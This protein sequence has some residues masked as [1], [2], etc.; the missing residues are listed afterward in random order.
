MSRFVQKPPTPRMDSGPFRKVWRSVSA[1]GLQRLKKLAV[2]SPGFRY[3]GESDDLSKHLFR[4]P[5]LEIYSR[6]MDNV[7][8]DH[9]KDCPGDMLSQQND[10]RDYKPKKIYPLPRIASDMFSS[11]TTNSQSRLTFNVDDEKE[12]ERIDNFLKKTMFWGCVASAFP[13]FF[14]NGSMFIRFYK[15][16]NRKKI[17]MDTFNTKSCWPKFD[18]NEDLESVKIRYI[19]DTGEVDKDHEPIWKWAQYELTK[20]ADI[21]YDNPIFKKEEKEPPKF[22][23]KETIQH[24][25]GVVQGVW[26][27]NGINSSGD[28]GNSMLNGALDFL[29]DMNYMMSKESNS[30]YHA[31]Y[32]ALLGFGVEGDDFEEEVVKMAG[33]SSLIA[34]NKP[35]NQAD[36]R[37]LEG[38]NAGLSLSDV[39][40]QRNLTLLQHILKIS[41]PNPEVLLGIRPISRSYE[42]AL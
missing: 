7:Q 27:K 4:M 37:F 26:I 33:G 40:I 22:S 38:S 41:L 5:A 42:N 18:A 19:Y 17:I 8:Y 23:V 12:Q 2:L 6:Y 25:L 29:D 16:Q 14:S 11:L 31:L 35:P 20:N 1:G 39:Y 3:K 24:N 10:I 15:T 30:L 9:L 13:S 34:T 32:P 28:D 21:E 36:L